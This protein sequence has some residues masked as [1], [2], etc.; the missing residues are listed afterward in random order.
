MEIVGRDGIEVIF[1]TDLSGIR[2]W[3]LTET[4]K[5]RQ[6]VVTRREQDVQPKDGVN[7]VLTIDS[8]IQH[9]VESAIAE[10]MEKW[11]PISISGLVIRPRTGEVL[12]LATL[13][14]FDPT[15][16]APQRLT[17][18]GTASFATLRSRARR[19]K[20]WSFPADST[21]AWCA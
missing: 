3:R 16:P 5:K 12:A 7:V 8:V 17:R 18:G 15:V 1:N 4:N 20:S 2:G 6:E 10:G 9:I 21:K 14:N 19:S 13:P 11:T